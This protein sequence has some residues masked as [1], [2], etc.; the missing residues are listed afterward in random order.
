VDELVSH[1]QQVIQ[2][3]QQGLTQRYHHCL[4]GR[5]E[6]GVELL[7]SVRGICRPLALAPFRHPMAVEGVG[8]RQLP[9]A[10]RLGRG[11]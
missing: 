1:S 10:Y 11:L 4:L 2:G 3:P 5:I 9:V 6:G 8:F 7:W